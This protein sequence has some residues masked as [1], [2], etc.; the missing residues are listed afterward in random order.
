MGL[1]S[2]ISHAGRQLSG[3]VHAV[4]R[5][6][7]RGV[8]E[9]KDLTPDPVEGFAKDV[10]SFTREAGYDVRNT[11]RGA[12]HR[13][14]ELPHLWETWKLVGQAAKSGERTLLPGR[15]P[16]YPKLDPALLAQ[17][18]AAGQGRTLPQG[19]LSD[20]NGGKHEP[21]NFVIRGS[22]DDLFRALKSQGWV[23]AK[24]ASAGTM[25]KVGLG[26]LFRT[27]KETGAPV[28]NMY[29]NGKKPDFAFN[30][31]S[32]YNMGRDHMRVYHQGKDPQTGEDV[33]A[34]ASTRD[35]A[36]SLTV[37]RPIKNDSPF[38]WKWTWQAPGFGH[39]TDHAIDG[40]RDLI[41][42]DLLKSGLVRDW[43]AVN[44]QVPSDIRKVRKADGTFEVSKYTT[45]SQI[46]ELRLGPAPKPEAP[47]QNG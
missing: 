15:M 17:A 5:V 34:V 6:I 38:P 44:A 4:D 27:S 28:S 42:H 21:V 47:V 10:A 43:A 2:F 14:K 46:Y 45:D 24:D 39:Q 26:V 36:I 37:K 40:E 41:M 3:A 8:D 33:W 11:A 31:N 22:Q 35:N 9:L 7:D 20:D 23:K 1:D 12:Y 18:K 13:V 19:F 25:I 30:K 32:D 29:L 16:A